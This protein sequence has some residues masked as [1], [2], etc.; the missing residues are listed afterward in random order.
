MTARRHSG[1]SE[2]SDLADRRSAVSRLVAP[3][4]IAAAIAMVACSGEEAAEEPEPI[5]AIPDE[6]PAETDPPVVDEAAPNEDAPDANGDVAVPAP[7]PANEDAAPDEDAPADHAPAAPPLEDTEDPPGD[8]DTDAPNPVADMANDG[9]ADAP[10]PDPP[11]ATVAPTIDLTA[12]LE[13]D[14]DM[15]ELLAAADPDAG[16]SY[17]QRCIGCHSFRPQG[18]GELGPSTGPGLFGIVGAPIGGAEGFEYSPAFAELNAAGI[19]WNEARL[20]AFLQDPA[21]TVPGTAMGTRAITD[22]ED[23]ANTIA[24]LQSLVPEEGPIGLDDNPE[25]LERIAAADI[26][27]GELLAARCATCHLFTE[28]TEALV[29]P[30]LFGIVGAV[31]AAA[32]NFTYSPAM[33]A[34]NADGATWTYD[35]LD[36]FLTNPAAAI[37]GTRMGFAGVDDEENRAAIIAFLVSIS[38]DAPN[39]AGAEI[40]GIGDPVPGL[41]RLTFT[42]G[43]VNLGSRFYATLTCSEC[44]GRNLDGFAGARVVPPLVGTAFAD[45]WFGGNVYELYNYVYRHA[46]EFAEFQDAM[47][48]MVLAYILTHN[49]FEARGDVILPRDRESLQAMGFFQ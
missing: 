16:Q 38:P 42:S 30:T 21:G 47:I 10:A 7:D 28:T 2:N 13:L 46:S 45:R 39:P 43:Q 19:V 4:L 20:D 29:G 23:R 25:L 36:S 34:L 11:P 5:A 18:P 12:E 49:G 40:V 41:T 33:L 9:L 15:A 6:A 44:H 31:V 14:P 22:A 1:T 32:E 8:L 24:F 26:E 48:P 35:R 17:T 3:L 37:P 27:D